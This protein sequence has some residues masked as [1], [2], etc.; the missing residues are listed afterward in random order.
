MRKFILKVIAL[1]LA[2]TL[3]AVLNVFNSLNYFLSLCTAKASEVIL[4]NTIFSNVSSALIN[5]SWTLQ[6]ENTSILTITDSCNAMEI[7]LLNLIF[8]FLH[9]GRKHLIPFSIFL[10]PGIFL[11]NTLRVCILF[12]LAIYYPATLEFHHHYTFTIIIYSIIILI[13]Y[14]WAQLN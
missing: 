12:Y 10:G 6:W 1:I 9:G 8:L 4:E 5:K 11:I 2:V 3:A 13:W 14:R 7:Y